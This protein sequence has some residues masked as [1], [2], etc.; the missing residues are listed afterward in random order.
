M[1]DDQ[2]EAGARVLA[3]WLGYK[4]EGLEKED[5]SDTW[6]DWTA[7]RRDL[8]GGQPA[9]RKIVMKIV[10]AMEKKP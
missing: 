4:W 3:K 1:T 9:L 2:I 8:Q 7:L 6:S 5:I 10:E